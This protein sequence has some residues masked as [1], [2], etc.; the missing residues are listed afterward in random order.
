[1][2]AIL[3]ILLLFWSY[4]TVNY[5]LSCSWGI[6]QRKIINK[7]SLSLCSHVL[8]LFS[9]V[10]LWRWGLNSSWMG[11]LSWI[12]AFWWVEIS[13]VLSGRKCIDTDPSKHL[14]PMSKAFSTG[15]I[16]PIMKVIYL[17]SSLPERK[18]TNGLLFD[19]W[20]QWKHFSFLNKVFIRKES[21][22]S[23]VEVFAKLKKYLET[24]WK[25]LSFGSDSLHKATWWGFHFENYFPWK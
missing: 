17:A 20:F 21:I 3:Q 7:Q 5:F 1:M 12:N 25:I 15:D 16:W 9:E 18:H 6:S 4:Q 24:L 19:K 2:C 14:K 10:L 22:K 13:E 23:M 8:W 11:K